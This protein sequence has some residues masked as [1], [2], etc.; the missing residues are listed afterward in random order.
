MELSNTYYT[1]N[2]RHQEKAD[3]IFKLITPYGE[4]DKK[5]IQLK[6]LAKSLP[7]YKNVY[8][9]KNL[10][11]VGYKGNVARPTHIFKVA[12]D[13]AKKRSPYKIK[14]ENF[15]ELETFMD[16]L[17]LKAYDEQTKLGNIK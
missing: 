12:T 7:F 5:S 14:C 9:Y 4:Y 1:E 10:Y 15:L 11:T 17:M 13:Y 6:K 2:G 16:Y 8:Y 3:K